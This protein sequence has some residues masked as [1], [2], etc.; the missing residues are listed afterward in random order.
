LSSIAFIIGAEYGNYDWP[1]T[2][3][4]VMPIILADRRSHAWEHVMVLTTLKW[5]THMD[6][7]HST[8]TTSY[9][10]GSFFS[11]TQHRG[12]MQRVAAEVDT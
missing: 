9:L 11:I 10:P 2:V 7:S 1:V 6:I 8:H 3:K 4:A 5:R 12:G